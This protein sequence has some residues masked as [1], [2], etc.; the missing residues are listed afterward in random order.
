[1]A[2]LTAVVDNQVRLGLKK[3]R[4]LISSFAAPTLTLFGAV[5]GGL[6]AYAAL[7]EFKSLQIQLESSQVRVDPWLE[8]RQTIVS[9]QITVYGTQA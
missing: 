7:K 5:I 1:G 9:G 8:M 4:F 3:D 2:A 6:S